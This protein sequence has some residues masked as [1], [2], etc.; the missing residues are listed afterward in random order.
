M[1]ILLA[2]VT[3]ILCALL[4]LLAAVVLLPFR[5][6]A[7]GVVHDGEPSGAVA[8]DW[9]FGLL[10]VRLDTRRRV[11]LR[12]LWLPVARFRIRRK[13][14][15]ERER[16]RERVRG[17]RPERTAK[18]RKER[19]AV[20]RRL[21]AALAEREAFQRMAARLVAALHLRL[22]A[23]GRLGIGDPADTATLFGLMAALRS[24]P[25]VELDVE[26]DWVDEVLEL[27]LEAAGRVWIAELIV[28][29]VALL[30]AR[31][32]RRALRAAFGWGRT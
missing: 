22:R 16:K 17:A 15:G 19:P 29:A 7:A 9:G 20:M 26:L 12:L 6:R 8:I 1:S 25:G 5:A 24:L 23:S 2:I 4:G 18:E 10:G 14:A 11:G 21:R 32:N 27:E 3:A 13:A 30:F 31:P 28:V